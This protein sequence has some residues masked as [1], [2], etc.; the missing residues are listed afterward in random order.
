MK[1]KTVVIQAL[2]IALV[3]IAIIWE[4]TGYLTEHRLA[5]MPKQV[6]GAAVLCWL[7]YTLFRTPQDGDDWAGQY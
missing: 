1:N 7:V 4:L 3:M 2:M 5:A 6:L